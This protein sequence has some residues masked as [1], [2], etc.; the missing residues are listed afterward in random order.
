MRAID[1]FA[2]WETDIR[3]YLIEVLQAMPS[4]QWDFAPVPE[5]MSFRRMAL[6]IADAEEGWRQVALGEL[7]EWPDY[8]AA[9]YPTPEDAIRLA[10]EVHRRT[11]DLLTAK[12]AEWLDETILIWGKYS[13][14]NRWIFMH[15]LEHEIHH[16]AQMLT[17]LRLVGIV[18]PNYGPE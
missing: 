18:P 1:Q 6:H 16:R 12:P 8:S 3:S 5:V 13:V 10:N 11:V 17:Y 7:N 15:V 9:D 2:I 14:T 4:Q